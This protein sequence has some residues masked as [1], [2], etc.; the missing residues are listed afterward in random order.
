MDFYRMYTSQYRRG[1][2]LRLRRTL[3]LD[4]IYNISRRVQ[5]QEQ[6]QTHDAHLS[7]DH[8]T[9]MDQMNKPPS[10]NDGKS[11]KK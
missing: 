11:E 7:I 5:G 2:L 10:Y 6:R 1:A 8:V 9:I 4:D 3:Q